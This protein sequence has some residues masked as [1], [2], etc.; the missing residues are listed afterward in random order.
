MVANADFFLVLVDKFGG[1]EEVIRAA[2]EI[3]QERKV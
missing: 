2:R 1:F 3:L